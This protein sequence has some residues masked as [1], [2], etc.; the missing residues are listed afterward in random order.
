MIKVVIQ[1]KIKEGSE[2]D[3]WKMISKLRVNAIPRKGYFSGE[4]W[5]DA[6]DPTHTIVISTWLSYEDWKVWEDHP[7]RQAIAEI[8]EPMLAEHA[9]IYV[10]RPPE[11]IEVRSEVAMPVA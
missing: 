6:N 3:F 8:L 10:M 11:G 1:R 2:A 9:R 5:V 4:T 7:S